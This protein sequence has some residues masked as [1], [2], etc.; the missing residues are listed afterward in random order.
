MIT[1][2]L[3]EFARHLSYEKQFSKHTIAA[4]QRDL[5]A[6]AKFCQH[7]KLNT[8]HTLRRN[9]C[10]NFAR[11]QHLSGLSASSIA[12]S[13]CA[14]RAFFKYQISSGQM[15]HNPAQN[16]RAPKA[17]KKLPQ[18][19]SADATGALLDSAPQ[20]SLELRDKAILELLYSSGMRISELA[21]LNYQRDIAS[22]DKLNVIGKGNKERV[23]L[24]GAA[25]RAALAK[26]IGVRQLWAKDSPA[27]FIGKQG[28]R[29]SVRAIQ[30]RV[31][32]FAKVHGLGRNLHPHMLRHCFATH[33]LESSNELRT[34]QELLGHANIS[35]TQIYT[36]L[37]FQKL[38]T[39][40]EQA[41]P[42]AKRVSDNSDKQ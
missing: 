9:H 8:T 38:A 15:Q 11:E 19:I 18:V 2:Q 29:L 27:L 21:S 34:V 41:H 10:Q 22:L 24:V 30:L 13:L 28:R 32:R 17:S 1:E 42:R 35:T 3:A 14:L 25:A 33:L 36:H 40:Y 5:A 20:D 37:D 16:V 31:A 4:Y 39:S 23:V 7:H 12:R 26:Y 6:F